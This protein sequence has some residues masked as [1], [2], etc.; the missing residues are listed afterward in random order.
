MGLQF[1]DISTNQVKTV[2]D[3]ATDIDSVYINKLKE[4]GLACEKT[5]LGYFQSTVNGM[6]YNFS[7]DDNAQKN[8]D[9]AENA[10]S[11]N[12]LTTMDWTVYD[13]NW[14]VVRLTLDAT[15]FEPVYKAHLNHIQGN[16]SKFRDILQPK[17]DAAYLNGDIDGIKAVVW[18]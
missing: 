11:K 13:E 4:L 12:Y 15:A 10:F 3:L 8:F 9:K 6:V 14:K 7:C 18:E 16:I 1:K 2:Q 5:I 17:V